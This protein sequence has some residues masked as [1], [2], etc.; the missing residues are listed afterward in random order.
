MFDQDSVP[1]RINKSKT[2]KGRGKKKIT[3]EKHITIFNINTLRR[4]INIY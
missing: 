4:L 3:N 1:L 2:L